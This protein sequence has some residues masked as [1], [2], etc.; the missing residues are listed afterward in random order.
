MSEPTFHSFSDAW[1]RMGRYPSKRAQKTYGTF[2]EEVNIIWESHWSTNYPLN[3]RNNELLF[4]LSKGVTSI[5]D[6]GMIK[7]LQNNPTWS[8]LSDFPSQCFKMVR[9]PL[10]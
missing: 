4:L 6:H 9:L 10:D 5:F 8:K 3:S 1:D 7:E 2:L